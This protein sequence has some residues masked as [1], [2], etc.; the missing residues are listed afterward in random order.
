M[1]ERSA[2]VHT[3]GHGRESFDALADRLRPHGVQTIVDVRSARYSK[4]APEF[5][6][7]SLE[8]LCSASGLG[9]RYLGDRLGGLPSPHPPSV[10]STEAAIVELLGLAASSHVVLLCSEIDPQ[11]CH[12][13]GTLARALEARGIRVAHILGDGSVARHQPRLSW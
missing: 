12:R 13:D 6:K 11:G 4:H 8:Q 9:Y 5:T 7:D 2:T 3:I 10:E 1:T